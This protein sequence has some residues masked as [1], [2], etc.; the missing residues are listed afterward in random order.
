MVAFGFDSSSIRLSINYP[1]T[2]MATI[3]PSKRLLPVIHCVSPWDHGGVAHALTNT[4]IALK[5]GADGVILIGHGLRHD[6][7]TYIY[8]HVRKQNPD[9]WIGINFLDLTTTSIQTEKLLEVIGRCV[10]L[11]AIWMDALPEENLGTPPW[12]EIFAGVA[13]KYRNAN[14]SDE[15]LRR[16]CALANAY[17]NYATTSGDKTGSPP[18]LEKLQAIHRHLDDKTPIAVASGV[19]AMNV[20]DMLPHVEIFLVASSI[21]LPDNTRG[22]HEYL[23]PKK[24]RVLADIIHKYRPL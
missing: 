17:A 18:R 1:E 7:L 3:V 4:K 21:C 23:I 8:G 10:D 9:A 24:V 19:D 6:D 16:E 22:G 11:S 12:I 5:N 2:T 15:E 20:Q 13:F 14:A